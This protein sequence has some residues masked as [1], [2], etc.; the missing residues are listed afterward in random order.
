MDSPIQI[1]KGLAHE[2][3]AARRKAKKIQSGRRQNFC[4][5]VVLSGWITY[6]SDKVLSLLV[7]MAKSGWVMVDWLV[8][9]EKTKKPPEIQL[10]EQKRL[11]FGTYFYISL[12][13]FLSVTILKMHVAKNDVHAQLPNSP[14]P[15]G[16]LDSPSLSFLNYHGLSFLESDIE[17]P[18][19]TYRV[20]HLGK[21]CPKLTVSNIVCCA[22][23][24]HLCPMSTIALEVAFAY[25]DARE[26]KPLARPTVG[27]GEREMV[28]WFPTR[29]SGVSTTFETW[30]AMEEHHESL[31]VLGL[32]F[33]EIC[34]V[35]SHLN[36]LYTSDSTIPE[37]TDISLR[38]QN[39][40]AKH[41]HTKI[42][43]FFT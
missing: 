3:A 37:G 23:L 1:L 28:S 17:E 21:Q 20:W 11:Y 14:R 39:H 12:F 9:L 25:L 43:W 35:L 26:N 29:N 5:W 19:N 10:L 4:G 22:L 8:E 36:I 34:D 24:S 38:I 31:L 42:L 13:W 18:T 27:C 33:D 30:K 32:K 6:R 7:D 2:T 40:L 16:T 15:F 41:V